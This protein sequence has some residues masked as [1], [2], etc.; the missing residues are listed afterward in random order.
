MSFEIQFSNID[1]YC[2]FNYQCY[3]T[4]DQPSLP[5]ARPLLQNHQRLRGAHREGVAQLWTQVC[6]AGGARGGQTL[7]H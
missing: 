3:L 2:T 4:V 5:D 1:C 7:R 6:P